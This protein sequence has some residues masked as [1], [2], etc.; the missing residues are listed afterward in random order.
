M[1]ENTPRYRLTFEIYNYWDGGTQKTC[2]VTVIAADEST[3]KERATRI[4]R[5]VGTAI[6]PKVYRLIKIEEVA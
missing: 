5:E 6:G 1:S 2:E 3:G 4:L